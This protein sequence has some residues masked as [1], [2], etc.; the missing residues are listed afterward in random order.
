[1]I[2]GVDGAFP[3]SDPADILIDL[4]HTLSARYRAGAHFVMNSKTLAMVRKFKDTDGN[5]IWRA[6]LTEG[7]PDTLLGYPVVEAEDMP[8]VA[9]DACAIAFGNFERAYTLVER[10]GTRVL[11]DPY[12]NKPYV[13]F[14]A[15]RRVGGAVVNDDALKLL[16][17]SD[18]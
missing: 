5:F 3:V 13:H 10:M 8:D 16:K 6:G 9:A 15:T 7:Q 4:V 2:T 17:F 14:Y 18:A 12:T 11:R 1:M